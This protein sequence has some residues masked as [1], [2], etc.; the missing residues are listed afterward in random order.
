M[1]EGYTLIGEEY[2]RQILIS[3]HI[4]EEFLIALICSLIAIRAFHTFRVSPHL[5]EE[6]RSRIFLA[7]TAFVILG[8]NSGLHGSIHALHLNQNLLYQT[9]LG[10]CIGLLTLIIAISAERPENKKAFP[11]LYVPLLALLL[12]GVSSSFPIF[13]EFRPLV[14]IVIAYLSGVVCMVY[15]ATFYRTRRTRFIYSA[16]GHM[17][18][19]TSAIFLFFPAEIGSRVWLYGHLLRPMGFGILLFSMNREELTMLGGSILYRVLVAFSLL[20]AIPLLVFGMVVFYENVHTI[21]FVGRRLLVFLLLLVTLASALLFGLGLIIRLIR[22][23]LYLRIRLTG[24][25]MRGSA[26][27]WISRVMMRS[28]SCPRH[29][30]AWL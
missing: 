24:W 16:L 6:K 25:P 18:I 30:T 13:G 9:L 17:I 20:A 1:Q 29:S 11:L 19:C 23:I 15:I 14:W 27:E 7:G 3:Y 4:G 21:D 2:L 22:P 10:Y 8:L 28:E 26:A 5:G 12:P